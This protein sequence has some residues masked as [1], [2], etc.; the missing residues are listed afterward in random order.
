[1]IDNRARLLDAVAGFD[2][3]LTDLRDAIADEDV[4][5]LREL[6]E[7]AHDRRLRFGVGPESIANND[8]HSGSP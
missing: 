1:M 2:R 7:L 4:G 3:R 6:W 5:R 8:S